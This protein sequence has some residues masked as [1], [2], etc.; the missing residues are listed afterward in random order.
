MNGA[1]PKLGLAEVEEENRARISR[2]RGHKTWLWCFIRAPSRLGNPKAALAG[3]VQSPRRLDAAYK[4]HSAGSERDG[5][6]RDDNKIFISVNASLVCSSSS[7]RMSYDPLLRHSSCLWSYTLSR[8]DPSPVI[9]LF[10]FFQQV[11]EL[12][13]ESKNIQYLHPLE[14]P[15]YTLILSLL[16]CLPTVYGQNRPP[17]PFHKK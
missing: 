3:F 14:R 10:K 8:I 4:A 6:D 15:P 11:P 5:W 12:L 17:L 2:K 7:F 1:I 13:A 9:S 16:F